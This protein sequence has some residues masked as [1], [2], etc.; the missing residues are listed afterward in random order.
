ME[1]PVFSLFNDFFIYTPFS[2][3]IYITID[4]YF[5]NSR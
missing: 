4:Y 2:Q 5:N 3:L 1:N